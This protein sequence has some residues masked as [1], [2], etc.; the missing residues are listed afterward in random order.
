MVR[1][2]NQEEKGRGDRVCAGVTGLAPQGLNPWPAAHCS[3]VPKPEM[4][5]RTDLVFTEKKVHSLSLRTAKRDRAK[6]LQ[7]WNC[8]CNPAE[9]APDV[10]FIPPGTFPLKKYFLKKHYDMRAVDYLVSS[11]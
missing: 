10:R 5:P 4:K 1:T 8:M 9:K 3:A 6:T 11:K 2:W 7:N